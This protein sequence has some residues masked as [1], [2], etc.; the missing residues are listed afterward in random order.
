M[1]DV[2]LFANNAETPLSASITAAATS[3]VGVNC[4][5]WPGPVTGQV[6]YATLSDGTN[7]PEIVKVTARSSNTL[8]VVRAQEGT[9]AFAWSGTL[10]T[11]SI[12]LTAGTMAQ[13]PQAANNGGNA[14]GANALEYQT[15]RT[16][17]TQVASGA[18][19]VCLGSS[20]T[21]SAT[22]ATTLGKSNTASGTSGTAI[23][24]TNTATNTQ[25]TAL[26]YSNDATNTNAT[27]I[28]S[29]NTASNT[30]ATAAGR[31][32][33]ASG[34]SA[35]AIGKSNTA[36]GASGT[37]IGETN[38]ASGTDSTAIGQENTATQTRAVSLGYNN[39]STAQD[40]TAVGGNN[41]VN[42][43]FA[44]AAGTNN[45]ASGG[46]CVAVGANNIAS[47]SGAIALGVGSS[48]TGESSQASG[49]G[50]VA[51]GVGA[52][53]RGGNLARRD[54]QLTRGA[55]HSIPLDTGFTAAEFGGLT[56]SPQ[57]IATSYID[58]TG[59]ATWAAS[60]SYNHGHAVKPTT[61]NGRQYWLWCENYTSATT[62]GS[63]PTW[64]TGHGDWIQADAGGAA[65]WVCVDAGNYEIAIPTGLVFFPLAVGFLCE[66]YSAI[67]VQPYISFG[68][69]G[70]LTKY[71][72]STQ[73]TKLG[74]AYSIENYTSL[75]SYT[76]G[77]TLSFKL[78]TAA[79]GTRL[80]GRAYFTGLFVDVA[81]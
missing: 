9:T 35:T 32:N 61:P 53:C 80:L 66:R 17:S 41:T 20:N 56:G 18:A 23:G 28:G 63:E 67:T 16:G 79:T 69:N 44:V 68:Q 33:T 81:S 12:R 22:N 1:A 4:G 52:I 7:A 78:Q 59:G 60:T 11:I 64:T 39:D 62:T 48:A 70:N 27:A 26:G 75:A 46:L 19:A 57:T 2:I 21:A 76:G 29:D 47:A 42:S 6:F 49:N 58:L 43:A 54:Y 38:S 10:T 65:W 72:A 34:T 51:K 15:T 71:L 55:V 50:A 31:S 13:A 24:D 40:S 14:R 37:A 3:I 5:T 45:T 74:A 77:T 73:T 36:S 25:A 8:T 30:D